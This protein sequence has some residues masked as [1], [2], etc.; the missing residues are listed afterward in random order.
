[1]RIECHHGK[2]SLLVAGQLSSG[3]DDGLVAPMDT[4][5]VSDSQNHSFGQVADRLMVFYN[6]HWVSPSIQ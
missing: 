4:I 3:G 6:S 1:M 5:E 2:L